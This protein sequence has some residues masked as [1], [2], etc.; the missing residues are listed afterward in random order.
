M[1][2]PF[3]LLILC[4][5]SAVLALGMPYDVQSPLLPAPQHD[6]SQDGRVMLAFTEAGRGGEHRVEIPLGLRVSTGSFDK[7]TIVSVAEKVIRSRHTKPP[8]DNED[9][10]LGERTRPRSAARTSSQNPVPI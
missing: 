1:A 4:A 9:S 10:D 3:L 5:L 7:L 8:K 2:S 6:Q